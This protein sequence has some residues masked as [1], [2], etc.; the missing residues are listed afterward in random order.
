MT[1]EATEEPKLACVSRC[2]SGPSGSGMEGG[3]D[4]PPR[5]PAAEKGALAPL[6]LRSSDRLALTSA[7]SLCQPADP[8]GACE[9]LGLQKA[10][11]GGG[12]TCDRE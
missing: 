4:G 2:M 10:A 3:G 11:G 1:E 7:P 9:G 6:T 5:P 12:L 8:E